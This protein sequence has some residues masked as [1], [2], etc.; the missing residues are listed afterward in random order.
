ML[1]KKI[2]LSSLALLSI[3]STF[4][5]NSQAILNVKAADQQVVQK[6]ENSKDTTDDKETDSNKDL[7]SDETAQEVFKEQ[8]AKSN[9]PAE[10]ATQLEDQANNLITQY[11]QKRL[12]DLKDFYI[13]NYNY[14]SN[15]IQEQKT[16]QELNNYLGNHF[17]EA[18]S[19]RKSEVSK[20]IYECKNADAINAT[21][22]LANIEAAKINVQDA[23]KNLETIPDG[24]EKDKINN[25]IKEINLW[26][27]KADKITTL[28]DNNG[29][30][31]SYKDVP[32]NLGMESDPKINIDINTSAILSD[33]SKTNPNEIVNN[34][35]PTVYSAL[36]ASKNSS[37]ISIPNN[38]VNNAFKNWLDTPQN[39]YL[40]QTMSHVL[41]LIDPNNSI[42]PNPK[43]VTVTIKLV[44]SKGNELKKSISITKNINDSIDY[45]VP[46]IPGFSSKDKTI[47]IKFDENKTITITYNRH[48]N[49]GSGTTIK[50]AIITDYKAKVGVVGKSADLFALE[51]NKV[52][53][54]SNRALGEDTYWLVSKKAIVNGYT[55]LLVGQNEWVLQNDTFRYEDAL[56]TVFTK[57]YVSALYN[58]KDDKVLNR[59]LSANTAWKTDKLAFLGNG[60]NAY[61]RVATNE[62]VAKSDV[63]FK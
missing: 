63:T 56:G 24:P 41:P 6:D 38:Y 19:K 29:N 12:N 7:S 62:F 4:I 11:N 26:L 35:M 30:L 27:K 54:I 52:K 42:K 2:V 49:G 46:A 51:G 48:N 3:S 60:T 17:A 55:Y 28:K 15:G 39:I 20:K 44:D 61:Y 5:S 25:M 22:T 1:R 13:K 43:T 47:N 16:I 10:V 18:S 21:A 37:T 14:D 50:P 59:A 36:N 9:V 40:H 58:K 23:Q 45:D 31:I 33:M 53:P 34:L 32:N 57:N 8:L